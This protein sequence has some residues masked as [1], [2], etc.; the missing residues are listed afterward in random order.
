ML[1]FSLVQAASGYDIAI[2][3]GD[4]ASVDNFKTAI[5]VS[6]F[7]D[8]RAD[9]AQ[10]ALPQARRGWIGD[11]VSPIE[12][13]KFGSHLWLLSQARLT[14]QTLNE[15]LNFA[16]LCLQPLADQGQA[17]S[18]EVFGQI[19]ATSG[20]ALNIAVTSVLGVTENYYVNLWENTINA[21]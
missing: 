21:A 6:L 5:E 15:T 18:I 2:E 13:L 7:S 12:G 17:A 10:I 9:A 1:D 20:I 3:N 14:Q 16:R 4:I 8:A 19:V 11:L